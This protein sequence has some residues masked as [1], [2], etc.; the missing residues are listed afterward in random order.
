MEAFSRQGLD[1][2]ANGKMLIALK[3]IYGAQ[4][5]GDH[6][7]GLLLDILIHRLGFLQNP[8]DPGSVDLMMVL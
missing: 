2:T 3:A 7:T 5:A 1:T 8:D 4:D 6:F